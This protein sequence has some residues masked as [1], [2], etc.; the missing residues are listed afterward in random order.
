[1]RIPFRGCGSSSRFPP[2]FPR[3]TWSGRSSAS[4]SRSTTSPTS[5]RRSRVTWSSVASWRSRS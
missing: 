5:A 2:T 1:M 4:A 3:P